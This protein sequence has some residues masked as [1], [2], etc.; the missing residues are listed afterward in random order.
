M[1]GDV[2]HITDAFVL[3]TTPLFISFIAYP[4]LRRFSKF[5]RLSLPEKYL[6][7]LIVSLAFILLPLYFVGT[8][9]GT[10]FKIAS[11]LIYL[12]GGLLIAAHV[13]FHVRDFRRIL[14]NTSRSIKKITISNPVL[15]ASIAAFIVRYSIFLLF[16]GIIDWDVAS[17]Y[18]P[19]ARIIVDQDKIPLF[20]E[21]SLRPLGISVLYS[22][23]YALSSSTA[24]ENFRLI[25][26]PL[27]FAV[28]I[29]T[30]LIAKSFFSEKVA[31]LAVIVYI[32]MPLHDWILFISSFYPDIAFDTL[33]LATFYFI[34]KYVKTRENG[35]GFLA[36]LALG[37]STFMKTQGFL[38]YPMMLLILS[39]FFQRRSVRL[40][41]S[42]LTPFVFLLGAPLLLSEDLNYIFMKERLVLIALIFLLTTV[43]VLVGEV[44][45][46]GVRS[47]KFISQNPVKILLLICAVSL[48]FVPFL[49]LRN[50]YFLGTFLS[51]GNIKNPRHQFATAFTRSLSANQSTPPLIDIYLIHLSSL[52][53]FLTISYLGTVWLLPKLIGIIKSI[54]SNKESSFLYI[55]F[56]SYYMFYFYTLLLYPELINLI[57]FRWL[58]P[59]APFLAVFSAVGIFF[60]IKFFTGSQNVNKMIL[61]AMFLGIFSTTQFHLIYLFQPFLYDSFFTGISSLVGVPW[62]T[63][64]GVL[65]WYPQMVATESMNLLKFCLTVSVLSLIFLALFR[66]S[67]SL[68]FQKIRARLFKM[69][70]GSMIFRSRKSNFKPMKVGFILPTLLILLMTQ[71]IPYAIL[72]YQVSDGNFSAF[73]D[74]ERLMFDFEGLYS[75]I[76]PYLEKNINKGDAIVAVDVRETGLCYYLD[77]AEFIDI[78][79]LLP[80]L[81]PDFGINASQVLSIFNSRKV[82]YF[83]LP[84]TYSGATGKGSQIVEELTK[85]TPLLSVVR[86][87]EYFTRINT[88]TTAWEL[89]E[90][91]NRTDK[92]IGFTGVF[93]HADVY[94]NIMGD[95]TVPINQSFRISDKSD[96]FIEMK[97]DVSG[98]AFNWS[99]PIVYS[100]KVIYDVYYL[101]RARKVSKTNV[102]QYTD[103][104][105][106]CSFNHTFDLNHLEEIY[107][108]TNGYFQ[109]YLVILKDIELTARQNNITYISKLSPLNSGRFILTYVIND[110]WW[111]YEGSGGLI[112]DVRALDT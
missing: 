108:E 98:G 101:P 37:L 15:I 40:L 1:E 35:Y 77:D 110:G 17:Y 65:A 43:I 89:Y 94:T 6:A 92:Y 106:S 44:Q 25:P 29:M 87:T 20:P 88:T 69:T 4:L 57:N 26:L 46:K 63:L 78:V 30:Y 49:L 2:I 100:L 74:R 34:Y 96:L 7:S 16:K 32:F 73:K 55:W 41:I 56:I 58:F 72:I 82:R 99:K 109:K 68:Y 103:E 42:S 10:G 90:F 14:R 102:L 95:F 105:K 111:V 84:G 31:T 13:S 54:R 19:D 86:N 80:Y 5:K 8:V 60:M 21:V 79:T 50:Y 9:I 59:I 28:L 51:E 12:I 52:F 75:E 85:R 67:S 18:L 71:I 83:L 48:P 24:A 112:V 93:L 91:V 38:L 97:T 45:A 23:V 62:I 64:T 81:Y 47:L 107:R 22:W 66:P 36:G 33:F 39:P 70:R 104:S 27:T 11:V 53:F 61:V 3:V 76:L